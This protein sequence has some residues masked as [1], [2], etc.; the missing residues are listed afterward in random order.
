[1][2][3]R[4]SGAEPWSRPPPAVVAYRKPSLSLALDGHADAHPLFAQ[5]WDEGDVGAAGG[6]ADPAAVLRFGGIRT[7]DPATAEQQHGRRLPPAWYV[8]WPRDHEVRQAIFDV[9]TEIPSG[10]ALLLELRTLAQIDPRPVV[11]VSPDIRWA[12]LLR[13]Q[14]FRFVAYPGEV[15]ADNAA[16]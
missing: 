4:P 13:A 14:G 2:G 3:S 8:R 10:S 1:M 15:S 11:V 6:S 16:D 12:E 7:S 5:T 9:R